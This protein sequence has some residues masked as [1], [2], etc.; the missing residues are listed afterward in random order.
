MVVA[1]W[2][3][4]CVLFQ[5]DFQGIYQYKEQELAQNICIVQPFSGLNNLLSTV[6]CAYSKTLAQQPWYM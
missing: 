5:L 4:T 1:R 6:T 2:R 3:V